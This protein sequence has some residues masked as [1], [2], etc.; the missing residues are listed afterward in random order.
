MSL[1]RR[2]G[3]EWQSAEIV[4]SRRPTDKDSEHTAEYQVMSCAVRW[5]LLLARIQWNGRFE[6]AGLLRQVTAFW[7][8]EG[9]F[10]SALECE[11]NRS[12]QHLDSNRRAEDVAY[13]VPD[14][15]LLHRG[16]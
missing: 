5:M 13:E 2:S 12:M 6:I 4:P 10:V 1:K 16:R 15:D 9:T 3:A 8:V 11:F 7:P 14:E